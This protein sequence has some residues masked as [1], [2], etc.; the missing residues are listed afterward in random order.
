[1]L[2]KI[3]ITAAIF[4]LCLPLTAQTQDADSAAMHGELKEV[5]VQ[6]AMVVHKADRDVYTPS[7]DIRKRSTTGLSLLGNMMIP[8]LSVNDIMGTVT[9]N[10]VAVQV[11]INGRQATIEQV[12]SLLPESIVRVEYHQDP[13]LRYGGAETVIDFIVRNPML[14]GSL[15][16]STMQPFSSFNNSG[17]SLKLNNGKSQF[18]LSGWLNWRNMNVYRDYFE[19][20][21]FEDGSQL[22]RQESPRDGKFTQVNTNPSFSYSYIKPDTTIIYVGAGLWIQSPT[23]MKMEGVMSMSDASSDIN[24][25][26]INDNIHHSPRLNFYIE[27]HLERR[28]TLVLD[29]SANLDFSHSERF[30]TEVPE[31]QTTPSVDI[32]TDIRDRSFGFAA[33][34]DYIKEWD[35]S[36]LTAGTSYSASRTRS[37]YINLDNKI[38]HQSQDKLYAFAEYMHRI[39]HVSLTAGIGGEYFS[40]D[41]NN[42]ARPQKHWS[43]R[44][45]LQVRYRINDSHSMRLSMS[46]WNNA[47]SLSQTTEAIQE[48]DGFQIQIGNPELK[49]YTTY[50][51]FWGYNFSLPRVDAQLSARWRHSPSA[52]MDF[53]R[54]EDGHLVLNWDNAGRHTSWSVSLSP[55]INVIPEWVTVS[56]SVSFFREYTRGTGYRHCIGGFYGSANVSVTHWGFSLMAQYDHGPT[57]LWGET[58]TRGEHFNMAMLSYN[59][60]GLNIGIFMMMPFD[61]YSQETSVLNRY[62]TNRQVLRTKAFENMFGINLSYNLSWGRQRRDASKII[63]TD[64]RTQSSSAAGR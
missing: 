44:P 18:E 57:S 23:R 34:A 1:M 53:R 45:H 59:L 5:T 41:A 13:G 27:Q 38:Y 16:A 50:Q 28:Q 6:A 61:R 30:Y 40:I 14:G 55:Q 43:I 9:A 3:I 64:A 20:F 4:P 42:D 12:R 33:E 31:G 51:L 7:N 60:N 48:I 17:L 10:G 22:L 25:K 32:N 8:S 62:N 37:K 47:P 52:V 39:G 2:H 36:R 58:K 15:M 19:Q 54:W 26:D 11:R 24:I 35:A 56:G 21:T 49:P 29:M 63:S 46:S